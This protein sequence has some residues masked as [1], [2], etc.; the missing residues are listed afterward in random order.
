MTDKEK[1]DIL[2]IICCPD[3]KSDLIYNNNEETELLCTNC[4]NKYV[5]KNNIFILLKK[6]S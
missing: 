5:K 6:E 4:K 1:F 3:C 2:N